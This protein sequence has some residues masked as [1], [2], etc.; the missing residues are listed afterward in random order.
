MEKTPISHDFLDWGYSPVDNTF[1]NKLEEPS[2]L[3]KIIATGNINLK[4]RIINP[5]KKKI[6][7]YGSRYIK[8]E[9]EDEQSI[10]KI[11]RRKK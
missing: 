2:K 3:D 10:N 9:I 11:L 5:K 1:D 6:I 8:T 4:Q 7:S